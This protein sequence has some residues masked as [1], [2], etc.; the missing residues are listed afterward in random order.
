MNS[1]KKNFRN[2][3]GQSWKSVV[4]LDRGMGIDAR[5]KRGQ[6]CDLK[7][8]RDQESKLCRRL[9]ARPKIGVTVQMESKKNATTG[10]SGL[11]RPG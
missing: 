1:G 7:K 5:K 6:S 3:T 10:F 4:H 9:T 2:G 8:I 11:I